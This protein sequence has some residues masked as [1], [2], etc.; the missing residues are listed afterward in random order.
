MKDEDAAVATALIRL[1]K[2]GYLP[3]HD[4]IVAF[5]ADEEVGEE[6]DGV[7]YLLKN[8]PDLVDAALVINPDGGSGEM[9][10]GKRLDFG[11][12]TSQKTYASYLLEVTNK[13]GHSSEPRP[14]N[15]IYILADGLNRFSHFQFPFVLNATTHLYFQRMANNQTGQVRADML[16]VA[17]DKPDLVAAERLAENASFNAI[18]HTTCVPTLLSGGHQEN[19]LPQR[20]SATLQCRIMPNETVEETQKAIERAIANPEIHVKLIDA[21]VSPSESQPAP[22][23]LSSV[24]KVVHSMWPGVIVTPLMMAGAS[25][26][27]FTRRAGIP[28]YGIGGSW[29][30]IKDIRWHGQ[31]ERHEVNDF[32]SDVEFTYRLMKEMSG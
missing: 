17:A 12:E 22:A 13:G 7:A 32:Y 31:D 2:E 15:A 21:V 25:D 10:D 5:T 19:A 29:N 18:L 23:L 8:H 30:N 1:K 28:S 20:A 3:D 11:I 16:A 24:E 4:I 9:A 27:I 14:D 6:Q 26:N